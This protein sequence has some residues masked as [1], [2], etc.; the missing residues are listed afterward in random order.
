MKETTAEIA[1]QTDQQLVSL[2]RAG[3]MTAFGQLIQRYQS[4]LFNAIYRVVGHHDDALELT[5]DAFVRALQAIKKFRS[6][7]SFYTWL[8]RIGINL[9]INHRRRKEKLHMHSL[10]VEPDLA[11]GQAAEL[12]RLADPNSPSPAHQAQL[13]EQYQRTI[14]ALDQ[15]EPDARAVVVLRDIEQMDYA[16]IA[17]VLE[18]PVGTVKSRLSRARM[19]L[20]NQLIQQAPQHPSTKT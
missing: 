14:N 4:R 6:Q 3:N 9:S 12:A 16:L 10:N 7:S 17:Q 20:R 5:Q 11:Q 15:L 1:A 19:T 2:S 8:F 18:V 13:N